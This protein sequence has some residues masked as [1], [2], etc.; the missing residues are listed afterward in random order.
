MRSRLAKKYAAIFAAQVVTIPLAIRHARP[1]FWRLTP[2]EQRR[3]LTTVL[4]RK[5][6]LSRAIARLAVR[7]VLFPAPPTGESDG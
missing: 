5:M 6:G 7:P 2:N 1:S 4:V 3:A